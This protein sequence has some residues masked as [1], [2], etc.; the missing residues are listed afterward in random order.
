MIILCQKVIRSNGP[1]H[2]VTRWIKGRVEMPYGIQGKHIIGFT[3]EET[4]VTIYVLRPTHTFNVVEVEQNQPQTVE[5][6][7]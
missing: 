2:L 1:F 6:S 4:E 7:P 3:G 5:S